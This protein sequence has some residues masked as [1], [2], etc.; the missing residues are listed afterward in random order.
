MNAIL[1]FT[2]DGSGHGLYTESFE[3]SRIGTLTIERVS[4]IEF[5]ASTQEWEVR[6]PDGTLLHSHPS[7]AACLTWEHH[8]FNQ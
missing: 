4:T 8:Y 2:K 1:T 3:L 6:E 7:R 5:N